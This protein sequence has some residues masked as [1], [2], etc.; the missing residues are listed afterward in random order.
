MCHKCLWVSV[1]VS[2]FFINQ[3]PVTFRF[4]CLVFLSNSHQPLLI[5]ISIHSDIVFPLH[6]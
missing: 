1:F 4:F 6:G 2:L 5:I 3:S